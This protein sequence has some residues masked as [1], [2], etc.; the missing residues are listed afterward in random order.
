MP[1][2]AGPVLFALLTGVLLAAG[3]AWVVATLFRR[4]MALLMRLQPAPSDTLGKPPPTTLPALAPHATS[5]N[6]AANRQAF[7]RQLLA[8]S[9]LSAVIGLSHSALALLL[10]YPEGGLS[11]GR[12]L[13]LGLVY[14][15][16][17]VMAWSL[18]QRWSW[19]RMSIAIALYMLGMGTLTLLNST[20]DQNLA[21][22]AGWLG[23]VVAI[24]VIV[25]LL[26]SASGRV[27]AVA[28]YLLPFFVL[29]AAGSV[30]AL[31]LLAEVMDQQPAWL[32]IMLEWVGAWGVLFIVVLAPWL[33]LGWPL[34]ALARKLAQAY[35]HK[36]FSDLSYMLGMYW[37]VV[38]VASALP[39]LQSV[40]LASLAQLLPWLWIP[41]AHRFLHHWL[42]PT[43]PPARLLVLR[44]FQQDELVERLFDRVIERWRL[45]GNTMMIAGTDL[46]S[47]TLDP[48]ELFAFVDRRLA[49][50][51][52]ANQAELAARLADF[53]FR[54]DPDGR[55]RVNE[56]YCYD[57]TWQTAL[58]A[59]LSMS[60]VVLM[61][62]RGFQP[63]N[64]GCRHELAELARAPGVH[65]VVVLYD[66]RSALD[67][68]RAD[69]AQAPAGRFVWLRAGQLNRKTANA[70]LAAL[71]DWTA[72][73]KA[74]TGRDAA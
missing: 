69:T 11:A 25:T 21:G 72:G 47:R 19:L 26:I 40:G 62:L 28:P 29:M 1:I 52:V 30:H 58:A 45:T 14:A 51:F 59:L 49:Q 43:T 15:W 60:D 24:P 46:I 8:W 55:Y 2:D 16:P 73:D 35:R 7:I 48:D 34:Y 5:G 67:T 61:D 33:L 65:R 63:H 50:R 9:L 36:R 17:M 39:G 68:A 54:P 42:R 66:D 23:G 22:V 13:L 4:R 56:C 20:P 6:A 10:V 57:S 70:T 32:L 41:L 64:A 12:W 18:L 38:L 37:L 31:A 44:V 71:H 3:A 74:H 27:R 53:D